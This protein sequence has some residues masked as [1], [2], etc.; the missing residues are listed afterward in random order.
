MKIVLLG[1]KGVGKTTCGEK[2]AKELGLK[3]FDTDREIEVKEGR[4]VREIFMQE[5]ELEL[6]RIEHE[7]LLGLKCKENCVIAVGGGGFISRKNQ[8]ILK[9]LGLLICLYLEKDLLLKRWQEWPAICKTR[10]EF[11]G[12]Y[13]MRMKKLAELS[14]IWIDVSKGNALD[15]ALGVVHRK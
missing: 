6:R 15:L 4:S 5:G 8:K 12:Y 13:E 3:F 10:D 9:G 1:L 14:C 7:V 2:L 11:D